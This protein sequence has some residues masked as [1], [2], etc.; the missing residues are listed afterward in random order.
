M[1]IRKVKF[2]YHMLK[3]AQDPTN[4][5]EVFRIMDTLR[6]SITVEQRTK[7]G[8]VFLQDPKF[9]SLYESGKEEYLTQPF[10]LK[11][12]LKNP[13]ASLGYQYAK[14]LTDRG[15]DPEFFEYLKVKDALTYFSV[16][17][18]KTHD[19]WHTLTGFDTN[20]PGELALQ[21]FY[22]G[23]FPSPAPLAIVASGLLHVIGLRDLAMIRTTMDQIVAGYEAGKRAQKLYGVVWEDH[24]ATDLGELRKSLNIVPFRASLLAA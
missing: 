15:F 1:V 6:D 23:Q 20:V 11:A 19:I 3:F 22:I 18:R 7:I 12:L 10:D 14:M 24:F 8:E 2:M 5:P 21:A 17:L 13:P 16:R 4:T 9:R